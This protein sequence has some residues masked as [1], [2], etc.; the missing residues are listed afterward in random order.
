LSVEARPKQFL[1]LLGGMSLFDAAID[2]AEGI[3]G[4]IGVTVVTGSSHAH[5]VRE[6]LSG[7]DIPSAVLVEPEPR[8]TAPAIIAAA[9][10][11]HP[12]DVLVI[13]PSDHLIL[14]AD[15][16]NEAAEA[17]VAI[18]EAGGVVVF[19]CMPDRAEVG[20][21]WIR[22]GEAIQGGFKIA[23]FVEK[24]GQERADQLLREGYLW[25]SGMFVARAGVIIDEV[26]DPTV[27]DAVTRSVSERIDDSLSAAFS[28]APSVS[29]DH[30]VMEKT[31]Q[32]FVVPLDAGWSDIGSWHAVWEM[33][34]KDGAGN[35]VLGDTVVVD[36][37]NSLVRSTG[38]KMAVVGLDS[39]V[40]VETEDGV[41][42]IPR[43]RAQEVRGIPAHFEGNDPGR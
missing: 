11:S 26:D 36:T 12:D 34:D 2:R 5:L 42:V 7:R 41:L 31:R 33:A 10:F 30:Q 39:V 8:N 32:G 22:P 3:P 14:D 43:D 37:T 24:P 23:E 38:R 9:L 27:I 21:G 35:V 19:G 40:V 20:Y 18:A 16:F 25:N 17:A 6:A 28:E 1:D 4:S 15:A 13:L 29:F